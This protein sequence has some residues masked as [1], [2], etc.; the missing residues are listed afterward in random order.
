MVENWLGI[1]GKV[2]IVTGGTSGIG[3]QIVTSLL[4]NDAV[5]YNIDL[6]DDP[7][8]NKDYHFI[9]TDVTSKEAVEK[10]VNA[11]VEKQSRIDVLIN[12]AGINL[13]RLLVDVKG[14]NQSM[15][16]I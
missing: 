9:E 5:V 11:I 15:K 10:A 8:D 12:N 1:N 4:E 7:V 3:R 6:K 16:L 14:E 2:I 13:P